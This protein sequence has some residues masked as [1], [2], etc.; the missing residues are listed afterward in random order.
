MTG[1]GTGVASIIL[2]ALRG[3]LPTGQDDEDEPVLLSV[4]TILTT[5]LG[6]S[7]LSIR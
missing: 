3:K 2:A 6:E 7:A 1:A 4:D 5:D